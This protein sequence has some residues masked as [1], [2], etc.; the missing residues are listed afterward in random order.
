M[1]CFIRQEKQLEEELIETC[2]RSSDHHF[3]KDVPMN[4][5]RV[6]HCTGAS[7]VA[8]VVLWL[9][10]FPLYMM[11]SPPSAHDGAAFSQHLL[12]VELVFFQEID[13]NA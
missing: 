13:G 10:Q 3:G 4:D 7:G 9:S 11:G 12:S 8:G 1:E 2:S 6:S 5:L